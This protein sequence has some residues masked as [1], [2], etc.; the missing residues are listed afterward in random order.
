MHVSH[1][2]YKVLKTYFKKIES[3][4]CF[5]IAHMHWANTCQ[6]IPQVLPCDFIVLLYKSYL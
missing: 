4:L 3:L 2:C 1:L 5:S 6:V